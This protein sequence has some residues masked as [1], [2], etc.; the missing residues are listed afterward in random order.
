MQLVAKG[1][2]YSLAIEKLNKLIFKVAHSTAD[3]ASQ[4]PV[5]VTFDEL[6]AFFDAGIEERDAISQQADVCQ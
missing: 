3:T 1:P 4:M 2:K 6:V 5:I